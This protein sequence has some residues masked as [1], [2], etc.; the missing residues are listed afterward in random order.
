MAKN[1]D[2][3]LPIKEHP[4]DSGVNKAKNSIETNSL[5]EFE[6]SD[7]EFSEVKNVLQQ[8]WDE[9]PKS[10]EIPEEF[11]AVFFELIALIQFQRIKDGNQLWDKAELERLT[12]S[13]WEI[14]EKWL[15][16]SSP[17]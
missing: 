8:I 17:R 16:P 13:I 9:N 12:A 6:I 10:K 11:E 14:I 3:E 15:R 5:E 2:F 4:V 1:Y 7:K